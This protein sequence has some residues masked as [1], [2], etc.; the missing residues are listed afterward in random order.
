MEYKKYLDESLSFEDR[1]AALVSEMTLEEKVYQ[2]LHGSA[3]IKRLGVK[4][5]NYWNEALHGVARAGVA[6]VFPQ[7][8]GLAATFDED[9][10]E[11]V[12]DCISTEGR[13]KFN[14]QQKFG[15]TDIYKG[16]TFWSPN[17]NIF[18]DPRWGRGH[19]TYGEDPYL[20]SRLGVRFIEGLQGHDKKYMKAAACAKHFAV[21]SGPEDLRHS[22]D[23]QVSEKDLNETYLPAFKACVQEG[24]V[25]AVMGAYNRTNGEPCCGSKTLLKDTLRDKWGF[26]GHVTSDCWAIKDFHEFHMVTSTPVESV[27]LAM[28]NGC[29]LNCGNMFVHLLQAVRD[30]LVKEETISQAVTRLFTTRMK[31]GLFD[32]PEKVP[33]NTISYDMVDTR[34]HKALNIEAAKKSIVLLKNEKGLLPLDKSK[35]KTVG[36]IGPNADNRKALI[37]N[38]EGTASEYVTVLEGIREYLGEEVTIRYSEG[39]HLFKEK[40]S[41]LSR[42]NDR[43]AE[44]KAIAESSDV[45]I[46]CMGLD[47]GLEG[48]EGD[49]GNEFASGDKPNLKLPG[50]QE[51]ILK[52]LT[53]SGKPVVLVLLSGSALAVTWADEHIPAVLQAWYPGAQGGRG[54]AQILFGDFSPEGKLPVTFYR[55]TEEL[56]AFTDYNM[57]G[58]TYRYMNQ[59]ALY[60]FGFG[61]SY[62]DFTAKAAISKTVISPEESIEC[63][64]TIKNTGKKDGAETV[65]IYVK[66]LDVEEAPKHQLK[67]IKKVFL[68]AGEETKV[69]ITLPAKAFALYDEEGKLVL[70]AGNY[71][72]FAGTSQPDQRSILLT[73]KTP[74]SFKVTVSE[75]VV[76]D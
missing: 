22:F 32:A 27:A 1:A 2:T 60:P 8:I 29:D 11:K 59:E 57:A 34:E 18:R 19:E 52:V 48:E 26:K 3:E 16:L 53:E 54:V 14:M 72:V 61:L 24:Q 35:L 75:T 20:T 12:A 23:A 36:V 15:D 76:L 45:I 30:G 38:Y 69:S 31:L 42:A 64:V 6:T 5:Y 70:N 68:K 33:Y 50:L 55:T 51:E 39:C 10:L 73:G 9:F 4:A 56:P 44:V 37:G 17:V 46:A 25:E 40:V 43:L 63:Q 58:R 28:N 66:A 67:G 41:G 21:H 74:E 71:E 7:A 13:A 65:Q 62:T 49:E 47:G